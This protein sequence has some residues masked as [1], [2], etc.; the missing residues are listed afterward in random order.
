MVIDLHSHTI[1][2]DGSLLPAEA[3][4]QAEVRGYRA[5]ALTDHADY[6]NLDR[7]VEEARRLCR[8]LSAPSGLILLAGV[9]IT[10]VPPALIP[11]IIGLSRKLGARPVV[12]HGETVVEP[13]R[14]GTNR[15]AIEGGADILAHPGLVSDEDCRLAAERGVFFELTSRR[16]HCLTNGHVAR[17]AREFGVPLLVDSDAHSADDLLTPEL[18]KKVGLGAGLSESE[19]ADVERDSLGL[20]E[21]LAR[22]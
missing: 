8:K 18:W 10:H 2:S 9:E 13:V 3:A 11:E 15:A 12:V 17:K 14:P 19:W 22:S 5:L 1:A 16:G 20:L 21:R 7:L 6:S 4:R